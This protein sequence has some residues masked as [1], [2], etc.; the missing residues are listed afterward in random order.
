VVVHMPPIMDPAATGAA[1]RFK[2]L[3]K[4]IEL[5][6]H[7]QRCY[8]FGSGEPA[9]TARF[10]TTHALRQLLSLD[11]NGIVE[12]Y[13]AGELDTDGSFEEALRCREIL[14]GRR[15]LEWLKRFTLPW[16]FGQVKT[17]RKAIGLHYELDPSFYLSFLR[18]RVAVL[19]AG[20]L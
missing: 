20:H 4:N 12:A 5:I 9:V 19:L 1:S 3:G 14:R 17:N 11:E 16:L 10:H 2:A 8:R 15:S 6:S 18:S 7:D 13:L